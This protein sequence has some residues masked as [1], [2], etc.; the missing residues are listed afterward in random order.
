[1]VGRGETGIIVGEPAMRTMLTGEPVM[2][3][4]KRPVGSLRRER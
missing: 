1:V 2:L 3:G 4:L